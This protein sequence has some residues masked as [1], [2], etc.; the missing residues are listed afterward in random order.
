MQNAFVGDLDENVTS[1]SLFFLFRPLAQ[2][3]PH[4]ANHTLMS[5]VPPS[6]YRNYHKN[7]SLANLGLQPHPCG[8]SNHLG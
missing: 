5:T 2:V 6:F 4:G 1:W 3:G 7:T 8:G